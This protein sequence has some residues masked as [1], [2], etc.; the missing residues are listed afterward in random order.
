MK[1]KKRKLKQ[2]KPLGDDLR[3]LTNRPGKKISSSYIPSEPPLPSP[4]E[5]RHAAGIWP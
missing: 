5:S 4:G 1:K 3:R 2:I